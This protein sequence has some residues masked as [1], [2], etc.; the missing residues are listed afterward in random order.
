MYNLYTLLGEERHGGPQVKLTEARS[1][2]SQLYSRIRN[3]GVEVIER[4]RE[5]DV[6]L[7]NAA[8]YR[9]LLESQAPLHVEVHP[10]EQSVAAWIR[11]LPVHAE[12][13]TLDEALDELAVALVDY[14]STWE[15]HLRTTP[16]HSLNVGYVRRVQLAGSLG[17]VR[18]ML[19]SDAARQAAEYATEG[20]PAPVPV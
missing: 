19:E 13:H 18:E 4:N 5:R 15:K 1:Q 11:G 20:P 16:N 17:A 12:G 2:L 10:G 7:A 8:E 6:V 14:A 9:H 3:G